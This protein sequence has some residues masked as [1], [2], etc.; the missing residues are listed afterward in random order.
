MPEFEDVTVAGEDMWL[1]R[2]G[3]PNHQTDVLYLNEYA[4]VSD[5]AG[6][7]QNIGCFCVTKE[8]PKVEYSY[9]EGESITDCAL[10]R[11]QD[12]W[13]PLGG[14][15]SYHDTYNGSQIRAQ[16]FWRWAE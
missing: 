3:Y 14:I 7:T 1:R 11:V 13:Y 5:G 6:M 8:R 2:E 10:G 9:C 16:A 4:Q 15:S 12:G